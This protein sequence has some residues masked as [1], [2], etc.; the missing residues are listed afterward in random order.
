M[1]SSV[2]KYL[3][4]SGQCLPR[5]TTSI[6]QPGAFHGSTVPPPTCGQLIAGKTAPA[7]NFIAVLIGLLSKG[8]TAVVFF[9][10]QR[11][12]QSWLKARRILD[13]LI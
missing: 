6:R 10:L 2:L 3:L 8:A 1:L 9:T 12:S 5:Y 13:R 11:P 7:G 4:Q